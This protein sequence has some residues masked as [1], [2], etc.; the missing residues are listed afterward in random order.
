MPGPADRVGYTNR[1]MSPAIWLPLLLL[2]DP[3]PP[4]RCVV[5]VVVEQRGQAAVAALTLTLGVR[6][7]TA[8]ATVPVG[9]R[10]FATDATTP[11]GKPLELV[12]GP[13]GLSAVVPQ[14]GDHTLVVKLEAPVTVRGGEVGF[15][16]ALPRAAI[17]TLAV[18]PPAGVGR[19]TVAVKA[20]DRPGETS[21]T[22]EPTAALDRPPGQPGYPLGPAELLTVTWEPPSTAPAGP[23]TADVDA[24]VRVDDAQVET[25]ASLKLRGPAG[26]HPLKL[27]AGADASLDPGDGPAAS[28]ARSATGDWSLT[29][30][31]G[32]ERTVRVTARS[33]RPP[34]GSPIP[35]GPLAA[36]TAGRQGGRLRV[37]APPTVRLS[38]APAPLLRREDTPP[39]DTVA[40]FRWDVVGAQVAGEAAGPLLT[41]DARPAVGGVRVRPTYHLRRVEAGWRLDAE[42]KVTPVRA[43]VDEL[44]VQLPAGWGEWAVGPPELAE[45]LGP[46]VIRLTAPQRV[47]FDLTLSAVFPLPPT[48]RDAVLPLPGFPGATVS[49]VTLTA[50]VPA[51]LELTRAVARTAGGAVELASKTVS[52]RG[53]SP[54]RPP[55]AVELGWQPHRPELAADVRAEVTLHDRQT[56][57]SETIRLKL[58]EPDGKPIRLRGPA[59]AVDLRATPAVESAGPGEWLFRPPADAREVT[60]ALRYALPGP[61]RSGRVPVGLVLPADATATT[62]GVRVWGG[63]RRP[64]RA[65]GP[66][67]ELP[68]DPSPDRDSLPALT[69]SGSGTNLPLAV[70]LADPAEGGLPAVAVDRTLVQAWFGDGGAVGVRGRFVLK[71]WPAGGVEVTLPAGASGP[72]VKIDG[73]PAPA[74]PEPGVLRVPLPDAREGRGLL[75][76]VAFTLPPA[77]LIGLATI[78]PPTLWDAD[79]RG[80]VRWQLLPPAGSVLAVGPG[81]TPDLAWGWRRTGLGPV[82]PSSDLELDAWLTSGSEPDTPPDGGG[83][84][85]GRQPVLAPVAALAVPR[86]GWVAG[87]SLLAGGVGLGLSRLTRRRLGLAAGLLGVLLA[88][89]ATLLPQPTAEAAAAAQP[90]LAGLAA[91]LTA[92]AAGREYARW[93]ADNLPGFT[94]RRPDHLPAPSE[95][96]AM[97]S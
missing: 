82:T 72:E 25:T 58:A 21:R 42:L 52:S 40:A 35:V 41:L 89:A 51:G 34:V 71:R 37:S 29:L 39:D 8:R 86:A 9:G 12:A 77:N 88:V 11:D 31:A 85:T 26:T 64:V 75:L 78:P 61:P 79:H 80:P 92:R 38:F 27:P 74:A 59:T 20:A 69:L 16:V 97:G 81:L 48:G 45:E 30:P 7:T 84:V 94:R 53:G 65:D 13:D 63:G 62:A 70:E 96:A 4:G 44:A 54:D 28:L 87:W 23:L 55:T 93:R 91:L 6:T 22:T 60:L 43:A 95:S 14:P 24:A 10:A 32:G 50:E 67:R 57:V 5:R 68:P 3:T 90:G 19:L 1:H 49:G 66:W 47:G 17:T 56:V 73:R 33:A 15:E 36:P 46:G 83:S 18:Q 76:D 2:A